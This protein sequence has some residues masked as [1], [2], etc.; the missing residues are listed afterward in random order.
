MVDLTKPQLKAVLE[1]IETYH[2]FLKDQLHKLSSSV[3]P[4]L[5]E[6]KRLPVRR[7]KIEQVTIGQIA[8]LSLG[9]LFEFCDGSKSGAV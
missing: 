4:E 9:E 2:P 5:I 8:S 3:L 1:L 7:L 6:H